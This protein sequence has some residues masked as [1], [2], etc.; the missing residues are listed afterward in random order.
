LY[1]SGR[2]TNRSRSFVF[3]SEAFGVAAAII[4]CT[5]TIY[6]FFLEIANLIG[7][8]AT[9]IFLQFRLQTRA[10][11]N[12]TAAAPLVFYCERATALQ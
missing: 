3:Y 1:A 11:P 6:T 7:I 10:A 4:P 8:H 9:A 5:R 2:F 12:E